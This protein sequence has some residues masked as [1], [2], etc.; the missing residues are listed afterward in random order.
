MKRLFVTLLFAAGVVPW[1]SCE[2]GDRAATAVGEKK[3]STTNV[4]EQRKKVQSKHHSHVAQADLK[5]Y[6]GSCRDNYCR[7][8]AGSPWWPGAPGD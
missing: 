5:A 1:M 7:H 2:A 3:N 6:S 4:S 8:A